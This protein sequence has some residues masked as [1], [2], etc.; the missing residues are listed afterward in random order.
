MQ[1]ALNHHI[2][3]TLLNYLVWT[4]LL[5]E[6]FFEELVFIQKNLSYPMMATVIINLLTKQQ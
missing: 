2:L 5:D 3:P 6:Q 1:L 4:R